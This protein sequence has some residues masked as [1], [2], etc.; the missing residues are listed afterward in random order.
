MR[1]SAAVINLCGDTHRGWTDIVR[2][3]VA[4]TC[5]SLEP[6]VYI[7]APD[8]SVSGEKAARAIIDKMK[9]N[10]EAQDTPGEDVYVVCLLC[11]STANEGIQQYSLKLMKS[12]HDGLYPAFPGATAPRLYATLTHPL[13]GRPSEQWL[14]WLKA[15]E[16]GNGPARCF[17]LT[18]TN[19]HPGEDGRALGNISLDEERFSALL[20]ESSLALIQQ[21]T[22]DRIPSAAGNSCYS[23]LGV[24]TLSF[25]ASFI[26]TDLSAVMSSRVIDEYL[27]RGD[28]AAHHLWPSLG[29]FSLDRVF[30]E[31]IP[32]EQRGCVFSAITFEPK[33][34]A[35]LDVC[36]L[37]GRIASYSGYIAFK[38]LPRLADLVTGHLS[39]LKREMTS[40]IVRRVDELLAED[41]RG[42]VNSALGFLRHLSNICERQLEAAKQ[43]DAVWDLRKQWSSQSKTPLDEFDAIRYPET[44]KA[45]EELE[46]A[47]KSRRYVWSVFARFFLAALVIGFGVQASYEWLGGRPSIFNIGPIALAPA[48]FILLL[49]AISLLGVWTWAQGWIKIRRKMRQFMAAVI[50][51]HRTN[52]EKRVQ[53]EIVAFY[54]DMLVFLG[55]AAYEQQSEVQKVKRL[56]RHLSETS[57][58]LNQ[59]STGCLR[60]YFR[61]PLLDI[62][63]GADAFPF[64]RNTQVLTAPEVLQEFM[65]TA[66]KPLTSWRG[67]QDGLEPKGAAELLKKFCGTGFRY[68][69]QYTLSSLVKERPDVCEKLKPLW[70]EYIHHSFPYVDAGPDA[71]QLT[72]WLLVPNPIDDY[73]RRLWG[74]DEPDGDL[75]RAGFKE[76]PND[77]KTDLTCLQ[78]NINLSLDKIWAGLVQ[79]SGEAGSKPDEPGT[80]SPTGPA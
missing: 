58:E 77:S 15:V 66:P 28:V 3:A 46:S 8:T 22:L 78:L 37:A 57:R 73:S 32:H 43:K 23:A 70:H 74:A 36:Q 63:G 29:D 18:G 48:W 10:L 17:I 4:E 19:T 71:G 45:E 26:V 68:I 47:I 60:T 76:L 14:D 38:I 20:A 55:D 61:K 62:I 75:R 41:Q 25:P 67:W 80:M 24:H 79:P 39:T 56:R 51:H 69:E 54:E 33:Q 16:E 2:R 50:A 65:L 21:G 42:S 30:A 11:L 64:K 9:R 1:L 7:H 44:Q 72:R 59:T 12:L 13:E 31:A 27:G 53:R 49:F 35:P 6:F 52:L 5:P 34:L 40:M